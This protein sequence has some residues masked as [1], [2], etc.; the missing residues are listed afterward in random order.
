MRSGSAR[1]NPVHCMDVGLL[2]DKISSYVEGV[3]SSRS[4]WYRILQEGQWSFGYVSPPMSESSL[5]PS[6][7]SEDDWFNDS[8]NY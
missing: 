5:L 6:P 2:L 1:Q 8:D 4:L 3:R 7:F